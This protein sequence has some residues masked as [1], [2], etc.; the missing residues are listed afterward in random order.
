[1]PGVIAT[2]PK[3]MFSANGVPM[4]GGTLEVYVAGTTTPTNTWQDSALTIA[5]TNP[6]TLDARGECVLW[7][8]SAVVYKFVLKNA[9]A[10]GG[11]VQWTQDNISNPAALTNT[12]R[13]DL[14]ASSGASLVGG[15]DQVVASI[16]AL[17]ALLKTSPSKNAFVTGYYA[18]GDGGGG[19]YWYDSTDTTTADNGGTVIVA[20]D[21]GRWKLAMHSSI[22]VKQFGAKGDRVTDDTAAVQKTIDYALAN[23]T[24]VTVTGMCRLTAS[25]VINRAVANYPLTDIGNYFCI[26]SDTRGGFYINSALTMF[27]S[28]LPYTTAPV[29]HFISFDGITFEDFEGGPADGSRASYVL[30]RS[31]FLRMK[32]HNC[33]FLKIKFLTTTIYIQSYTFEHCNMRDWAGTFMNSPVW[34]FDVHLNTCMVEHSYSTNADTGGFLLWKSPQG[35]SITNSVLEGIGGRAVYFYASK[36]ITVSGNYFEGNG[37]DIWMESADPNYGVS[38]IG[39][40]IDRNFTW[41]SSTVGGVSLGNEKANAGTMHVMAATADVIIRDNA[42]SGTVSGR[43]QVNNTFFQ[44]GPL[45][46]EGY[47]VDIAAAGTKVFDFVLEDGGTYFVTIRVNNGANSVT[48]NGLFMV[49]RQGTG[50]LVTQI[51]PVTFF[52]VTVNALFQIVITNTDASARG[53]LVTALRTQ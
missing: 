41:G 48:S 50:T 39:N 17:R 51:T 40:T 53:V 27:T 1:M 11:V 30:D 2:I 36:S 34:N 18:A 42:R 15:G 44:T 24:S 16:I 8:D 49:A 22:D 5:N 19:S 43:Y 31:V 3:F 21:G 23:K 29:S 7:L 14:A 37:Q 46:R 25:I 45:V 35:C 6:I 28:T 10:N 13:A 38:L 12:L 9:P 26:Q 33:D 52:T 20:T 32:F 47:T 4:V